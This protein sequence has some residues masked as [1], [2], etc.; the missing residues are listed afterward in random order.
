MLLATRTHG[1]RAAA[2]ALTVA[3]VLVVGPPPLPDRVEVPVG[4]V[5]QAIA[6]AVCIGAVVWAATKEKAIRPSPHETERSI[7]LATA[8]ARAAPAS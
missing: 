7:D 8:G 4:L 2:A 5:F 6:I 3:W 1:S